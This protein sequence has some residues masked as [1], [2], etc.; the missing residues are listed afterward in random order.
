MT[1]AVFRCRNLKSFF[2]LLQIADYGRFFH[3]QP[4]TS[5]DSCALLF[6]HH[7]LKL[8]FALK[9]LN[10]QAAVLFAFSTR[11]LHS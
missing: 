6:A 7:P 3:Q 1:V 5:P 4:Q 2:D 8:R 10:L 11:E 9:S